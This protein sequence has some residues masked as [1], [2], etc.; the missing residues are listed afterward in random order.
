[1]DSKKIKETL[2]SLGKRSAITAATLLVLFNTFSYNDSGVSTRLQ[3]PVL[4]H[5]WIKEE[6]FYAHIPFLSKTRSYNQNGTIASSDDNTII[7][8]ASLTIQPRNLQ[9]ADS[10]EMHLE[11]AMRY[12]IPKDDE[13]LELMHKKVKSEAN[14]LGNT[15]MPFAQTLV[16]DSVNQMLGEQFAQ[17]GRNTLRT[18]IDNQSQLGMYQTRVEKV[19][20]GRSNGK[21]SNPIVGGADSQ[22]LVVTKVTYLT[23][24][25]GKRLRSPLGLDQYGIRIVPNSISVIE[26]TPQGRLV[27]YIATK[28]RNLKLQIDQDEKQKILAK[29]THTAKLQGE[30][31]LVTR[32]NKLNIQKQEA[33]ISAERKVEEARLQAEKE[34]VERQKV[35]DL[36]IIDKTRQLQEAQANE[37]IQKANAIAAKYEASA[38]KEVGFAEAAVTQQ[39]Y[40]A[41]DPTILAMEVDKAKALALYESSMTVNMPTVV[42]QGSGAGS[43][44][45]NIEVMSSLK[46]MESL[47]KSQK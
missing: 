45:S 14:L 11:W 22:E 31:D 26:A 44:D 28:Q 7:D 9:F 39:K 5:K 29:E 46:I 13:S 40:K 42:Q 36:A 35:A 15:I 12:E 21:G 18:L 6:G 38:I 32:T 20:T 47:G 4:G 33:I 1:L 27:E 2:S 34:R 43:T 17:G 30:K 16:N 19:A 37:G 24:T 41:I 10:Y 8:T 3:Q 23:D 25:S